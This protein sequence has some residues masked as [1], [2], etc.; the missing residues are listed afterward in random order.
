MGKISKIRKSEDNPECQRRQLEQGEILNRVVR[1]DLIDKLRFE[2]ICE[3]NEGMNQID[4]SV[5]I[6]PSRKNRMKQDIMVLFPPYVLYL[7]FVL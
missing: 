5:K 2:Q 7:P 4:I 1:V 3:G 6:I